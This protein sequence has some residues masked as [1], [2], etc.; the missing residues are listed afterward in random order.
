MLVIQGEK[1]RSMEEPRGRAEDLKAA[2]TIDSRASRGSSND[3]GGGG[4]GRGS[5]LSFSGDKTLLQ[6]LCF[7]FG[8]TPKTS[9]KLMARC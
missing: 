9:S 7:R 1:Q 6:S 4:G 5:R 2:D 8:L 3:G